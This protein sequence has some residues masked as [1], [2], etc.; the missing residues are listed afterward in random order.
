M[1]TDALGLCGSSLCRV[2]ND[3]EKILIDGW[4]V[5]FISHTI[6]KREIEWPMVLILDDN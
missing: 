6:Q 2:N 3:T 4:M 1:L 5:A